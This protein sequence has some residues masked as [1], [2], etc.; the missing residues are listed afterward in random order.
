MRVIEK[1]ISI[2]GEGVKSGFLA[3]FIRFAG[4]NLRCSYCDTTYSFINPVY[5]DLSTQ[6]IVFY[7]KNTNVK[8]VTL[9][10][11]E[12]LMQEGIKDLLKSLAAIDVEVEIE[13]NGSIDIRPFMAS[14][15][16]F[17]LD[18]KTKTSG[19]EGHMNLDNYKYLRSFDTIKF[20]C[21][22]IYDLTRSKYIIDTYNLYQK[23][24]LIISPVYGRIN[25]ESIVEFMK[26]N[27]MNYVRLGLQIHKIIWD[28]D[29]RGV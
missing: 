20:V 11:G 27:N 19:M 1:F 8:Y 14:N 16:S 9:T 24:N 4:C 15:V 7:I 12:P 6:D 22:D 23:C 25:L 26:E 2:N 29:K 21:G 18:Y 5:E 28:K 3:V 13:T 10:G 17:T